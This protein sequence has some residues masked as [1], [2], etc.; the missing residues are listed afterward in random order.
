M[1]NARPHRRRL[2]PPQSRLADLFGPLDGTQVP[3]GCEHCNAY[4][5]V[6]PIEAGAWRIT[7]HHDSWCPFLATWEIAQ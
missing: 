3:G 7:V 4:Q 6:T 2:S 5:T 1:S